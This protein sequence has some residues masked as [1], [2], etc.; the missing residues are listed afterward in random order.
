MKNKTI[1]VI[2]C[3]Y[4]G[5]KQNMTFWGVVDA[6]EN[7][8]IKQRILNGTFFEQ[9][10]KACGEQHLVSYPML[11][12][13]K[14]NRLMIYLNSTP[15]GISTAQEAIDS[16]RNVVAEKDDM[17]IRIVT[18]PNY[19]REKLRIFDMGFDD[20]VV[21]IVKALILEKVCQEKSLGPV[22]DVLCWIH[23]NGDMDVDIFANNTGT[24]T[25]K[26]DFYKYVEGKVK[27]QLDSQAPNPSEVNLGF[28]IE[29]LARNHF[30]CE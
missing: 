12:E 4:C 14:E 16:R 8:K 15:L 6:N 7:P 11:Y 17:R 1:D 18:S 19:L 20:R 3:P 13:D 27:K 28:A 23:N 9:T 22:D 29:F 21:E 24:L 10:C 26:K 25:V 2:T 5:H 30:V